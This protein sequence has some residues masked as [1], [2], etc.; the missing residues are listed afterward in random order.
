MRVIETL[1]VIAGVMC[2]ALIALFVL[3]RGLLKWSSR[4]YGLMTLSFIILM[5]ANLFTLGTITDPDFALLCVRLVAAM[6]T[7]VLAS[8]YFL[9]QFL[10]IESKSRHYTRG[11]NVFVFVFS[12]IVFFIHFTPLIYREAYINL[13]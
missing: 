3:S 8:L 12:L 4:A 1:M 2:A 9:T 11:V 10:S 7:V 5:I 6:T 13:V